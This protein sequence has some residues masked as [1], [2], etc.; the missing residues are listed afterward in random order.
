MEKIL[1]DQAIKTLDAGVSSSEKI[2]YLRLLVDALEREYCDLPEAGE[3]IRFIVEI[4]S[5][6]E[7]ILRVVI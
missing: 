3:R 6:L 2:K 4:S 5:V 7:G 1:T